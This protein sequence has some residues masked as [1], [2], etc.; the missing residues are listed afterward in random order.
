M[1][2]GDASTRVE[3]QRLLSA[4]GMNVDAL[5]RDVLGLDF[6]AAL[7]PVEDLGPSDVDGFVAHHSQMVLCA[8][9]AE[10]RDSTFALCDEVAAERSRSEWDA[11]KA[12]LLAAVGV[13]PARVLAPA[14]YARDVTMANAF[15]RSISSPSVGEST[16]VRRALVL[17][18]VLPSGMRAVCFSTSSFI[19]DFIVCG[20]VRTLCTRCARQMKL[21]AR[22][23]CGSALNL[24]RSVLRQVAQRRAPP[25]G[26][27]CAMSRERCVF[28]HL[29]AQCVCASNVVW[30]DTARPVALKEGFRARQ[31]LSFLCA[32]WRTQMGRQ[33]GGSEGEPCIDAARRF[34]GLQQE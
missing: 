10:A 20:S 14:T 5:E 11:C 22:R 30:Q 27:Y 23:A 16:P 32:Q 9:I 26:V 21:V 19:V 13:R 7:L 18:T 34:I 24:R 28:A 4:A 1:D 8:T 25:P 31:G 6:K 29:L 17:A 2:T 12:R 15:S 33:A 3:A